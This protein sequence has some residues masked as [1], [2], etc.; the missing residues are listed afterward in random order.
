MAKQL[1]VPLP[2]NTFLLSRMEAALRYRPYVPVR[3][4]SETYN[5]HKIRGIESLCT[6]QGVIGHQNSSNITDRMAKI[7]KNI[8]MNSVFH[9]AYGI[10]LA[11]RYHN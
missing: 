6:E 8:I 7:V 2:C 10:T 9:R 3:Q 11:Y 4:N 5:K 1:V